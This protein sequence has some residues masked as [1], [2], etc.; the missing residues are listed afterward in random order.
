MSHSDDEL[1][2]DDKDKLLWPPFGFVPL[3]RREPLV[4]DN[5]MDINL[6]NVKDRGGRPAI[7]IVIDIEGADWLADEMMTVWNRTHDGAAWDLHQALRE[8]VEILHRMEAEDG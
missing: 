6:I 2:E 3:T 4:G 8:K 5:F 7:Q 1:S